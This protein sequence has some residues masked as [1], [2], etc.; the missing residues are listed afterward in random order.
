MNGTEEFLT[1][2]RDAYRPDGTGVMVL[3]IGDHK[4]IADLIEF[5]GHREP[6]RLWMNENGACR[7]SYRSYLKAKEK[8]GE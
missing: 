2:L 1:R 8:A 3:E 5:Q 6:L 7:I 4:H